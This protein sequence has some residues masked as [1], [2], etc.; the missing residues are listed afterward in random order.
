LVLGVPSLVLFVKPSAM[1]QSVS[2]GQPALSMGK[3]SILP[4]ST[5]VSVSVG[6]PSL[7]YPQLISPPS[8]VHVIDI[9]QPILFDVGVLKPSGIIQQ[10][11][12]GIP[13]LHKYV[14]HVILEGQY[15]IETPG[16]NRSF[17]VGQDQNGYPVYGNAV[18]SA[19]LDLVGERL[20][21]QQE[22]AIP[23][24]SQVAS[25]ANAILSK[26]RLTKA[27]GII[28]IP[29]NCGQEL[30]DV[31]QISDSGANRS[32]SKYRVVGIRFEY[33]PRQAKYEHRLFLGAP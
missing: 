11:S 30:F 6:E 17:V 33:N 4:D 32:A 7:S 13:T 10:V 16:V 29:P 2:V 21:C 24:D 18:D 5:I 15:A 31:V 23:I 9:G 22:L 28:L 3:F 14:W 1:V 19:E 26:M 25:V 27:M 12:I 20:D 8:I